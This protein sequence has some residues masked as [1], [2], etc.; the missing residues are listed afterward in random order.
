MVASRLVDAGE[1]TAGGCTAPQA[2]YRRRFRELCALVRRVHAH[3]AIEADGNSYSVP[4]RPFGAFTS[5]T[6]SVAGDLFI[7]ASRYFCGEPSAIETV[8]H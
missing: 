6:K 1:L 3:C 8:F 2:K 7:A 5:R 4:W